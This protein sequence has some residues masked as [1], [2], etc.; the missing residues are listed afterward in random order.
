MALNIKLPADC[1][2]VISNFIKSKVRDS[3]TNGIIVGL[4]GGLDSAVVLKLC[5][6]ALGADSATALLM[7]ETRDG[8]EH[9]KDAEE[10]AKG[11]GVRYHL[12][13]IEPIIDLFL[14]NSKPEATNLWEIRPDD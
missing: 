11:L 14:T 7:P 4:S 6:D 8:D 10:L 1:Q 5:S 3:A 13:E 12:I 9:F 2:Q